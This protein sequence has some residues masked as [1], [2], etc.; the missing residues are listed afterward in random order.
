MSDISHNRVYIPCPDCTGNLVVPC[1]VC[2]GSGKARDSQHSCSNCSG[3]GWKRCH[4]C[5]G[6][7]EIMCIQA[8]PTLLHHS[9]ALPPAS[10]PAYSLDT[11]M[12]PTR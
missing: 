3:T 9:N 4:R 1:L 11:E 7:G 10:Y 8:G 6:V 12:V 2:G 5:D